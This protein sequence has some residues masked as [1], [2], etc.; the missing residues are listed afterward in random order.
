MAEQAVEHDPARKLTYEAKAWDHFP[1]L[2]IKERPA[3]WA[4]DERL[5]SKLRC[6]FKTNRVN[7]LFD[8]LDAMLAVPI[9]QIYHTPDEVGVK[10][11]PALPSQRDA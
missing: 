5:F 11:P 2:M 3:S 10:A 4:A 8:L 1:M 6:G 9:R 7:A